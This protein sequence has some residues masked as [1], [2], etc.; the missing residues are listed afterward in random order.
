MKPW[1]IRFT[2]KASE[3]MPW[4]CFLERSCPGAPAPG[5]HAMVIGSGVTLQAA[6]H[7][8][9]QAYRRECRSRAISQQILIRGGW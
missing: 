7:V 1:R 2:F 3:R 8:I 6:L 5:Y 4:R 9:V